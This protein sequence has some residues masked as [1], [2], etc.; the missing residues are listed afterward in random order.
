[1][2]FK[3]AWRNVWR[4]RRRSTILVASIT[5]GICAGLLEMAIL[6]GMAAQQVNAAVR[7]RLSHLQVHSA[8]FR[9]HEDVGLFVPG[10]DSVLAAVRGAPGVEAA[11]GRAVLDAMAAS[12][13][14]AR[15]VRLLG[16]D[17]AAERRVTDL[18]SRM[19]EGDWFGRP[20]RDA[21][22]IGQRL[23]RRLG[24]RVGQKIVLTA[25]GG[26]GGVGGG[27]FRIVG[28]YRTASSDF[29]ETAVFVERADLARTFALDGRLYEIAVRV[30]GMDDIDPV[31]ATLRRRLPALDVATW[32]TLAPEVAL[33]RDWTGEMNGI[34]LFVILV[35]LV[36]GTTNTMLMGVLE[37]TRELGVLLALGMRPAR[38]FGMIVLETVLLS[39][40][41]GL[42]GTALAAAAIAALSRT[43]IDLSVVAGGLAALGMDRVIRPLLPVS[44][45][46]G[47]VV[48][49][50]FTAVIAS[51]YPGWKAVRLDPVIAMRTYR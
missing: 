13:S 11:A 7:T 3:I 35:A 50:A 47:V 42:A 14:T 38:V 28:L 5:V 9:N 10:G 17:P 1:M 51:L 24:V 27:A 12:A 22:V 29:D 36:F 25:Q 26:D 48:L 19:V 49:V 41:G 16:V 39:L 2:L 18:P 43:G 4:S 8:G 37:R 44:S 46:P 32:R 15:G 30:R 33:T 23:A 20:R 6:N 40:V 31:A 21:A 34:F 45:Y